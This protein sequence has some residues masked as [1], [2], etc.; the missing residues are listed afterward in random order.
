[1]AAVRQARK[2]WLEKLFSAP[3]PQDAGDE[4]E[5]DEDEKPSLQPH[6]P[7]AGGVAVGGVE[8]AAPLPDAALRA[9]EARPQG[10]A[11]PPLPPLAAARAG[12]PLATLCVDLADRV[13]LRIDHVHVACPVAT[14]PLGAVELRRLPRPVA[15][16]LLPRARDGR[17]DPLRIH[18]PNSIPLPLAKV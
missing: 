16:P 17:D 4:E 1:V 12:V 8:H 5:D 13:V 2:E 15:V 7:H 14:H 10:G 6:P 3:I 11:A 9:V 18:A